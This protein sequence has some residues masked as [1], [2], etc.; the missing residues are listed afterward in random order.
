MSLYPPLVDEPEE[1]VMV[2]VQVKQSMC[3]ATRSYAD[4]LWFTFDARRVLQGTSSSCVHPNWHIGMDV[5]TGR[6]L[7]ALTQDFPLR[8][9]V[10]ISLVITEADILAC[11]C[12]LSLLFIILP[13]SP[14]H[15]QKNPLIC[16]IVEKLSKLWWSEREN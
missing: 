3:H 5:L 4:F 15:F 2:V 11:P 7:A 9:R 1:R 14:R 10:F 6:A 8:T 13:V 12:S 16:T